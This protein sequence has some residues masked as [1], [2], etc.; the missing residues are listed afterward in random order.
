MSAGL[1]V[2]VKVE[3]GAAVR[4]MQTLGRTAQGLG[5]TVL[6]A[7]SNSRPLREWNREL[8]RG[9][10]QIQR[11]TQRLRDLQAV[12]RVNL[13]QQAHLAGLQ[14][15]NQAQQSRLLQ[16]QQII[17]RNN[18]QVGGV[19]GQL[20]QARAGQ[21]Q[22]QGSRPNPWLQA[23]GM[24]GKF[25]VG[26]ASA[27]LMRE[28]YV[29]LTTNVTDQQ[30]LADLLPRT[31]MGRLKGSDTKALATRMRGFRGLGYSGTEAIGTA[32][33]LSTMGGADFGRGLE[34]DTGAVLQLSRLFGLRP[35]A[36]A[37]SMAQAGRMGAFGPGQA[38]QFA[39]MLAGE[40]GRTGLGPRAAEVQEATLRLLGQQMATMPRADAA[41]ALALQSTLAQSRSP[42]WTGAA[43]ANLISTMQGAVT[44]ASGDAQLASLQAV[45]RDQMGIT[46]FYQLKRLKERGILGTPGLMEGYIQEA[47]K[48]NPGNYNGAVDW[49]QRNSNID[50][51]QW[52][53]LFGGSDKGMARFTPGNARANRGRVRHWAKSFNLKTGASDAMGLSGNYLRK[54]LAHK[55]NAFAD[56]TDWGIDIAAAAADLVGDIATWG[57]GEAKAVK[58][59]WPGLWDF[60]RGDWEGDAAAAPKRSPAAARRRAGHRA[61]GRPPG[62]VP[63]LTPMDPAAKPYSTAPRGKEGASLT[64]D[65]HITVSFAAPLAPQVHRQFVA[66]VQDALREIREHSLHVRPH[67]RRDV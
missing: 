54:A 59:L 51:V 40:I 1:A 12:Q 26:A 47:R 15:P 5:K 21:A 2:G 42:G 39:K 6:G 11:Y 43:G 34:G 46:G 7:F 19:Q 66:A 13:A 23:L 9:E 14:N 55:S 22:L 28:M 16:L 29:G 44:G 65:H 64:L 10:R 30:L 38:H 25:A 61:H 53:A 45:A 31:R 18:S 8:E 56:A 48:L 63:H 62:G 27:Y 49:L 20:Q 50:D 52:D 36:E 41:G 67:H 60:L 24:G 32:A 33:S 37:D 3:T 35:A 58:S 17:A 57:T 4:D